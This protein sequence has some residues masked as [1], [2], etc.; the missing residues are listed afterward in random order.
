MIDVIAHFLSTISL[1][2]CILVYLWKSNYGNIKT[3]ILIFMFVFISLFIIQLSNIITINFIF[4]KIEYSFQNGLITQIIC[5]V[6]LILMT[7]LVPYYKI[8]I[9]I[10]DQNPKFVVIVSILTILC[11]GITV[12]W[13]MDIETFSE[14][15]MMVIIILLMSILISF[16]VIQEGFISHSYLERVKIYDTYIP[17]V[18]DM[19]DDLKLIQHDYHNKLQSLIVMKSSEI[20]SDADILK[21][22]DAIK[23]NDIWSDL[24]KLENKV[25]VGLF[26][27]KYIEASK[28]MIKIDFFIDLNT[29]NSMYYEFELVEMYG[30]MLL[31]RVR[32][33]LKFFLKLKGI[34]MYSK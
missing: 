24:L 25:L 1:G 9:F 16:F 20:V 15:I 22:I 6:T 28:K 3:N 34:F 29:I 31:N 21:Y 2:T 17:I 7:K 13:F 10:E 4:G 12:I 23:E 32:M 33:R 5:I 11:Y 26:Y 14:A 19:V 27:S 8:N 18:N 30:I